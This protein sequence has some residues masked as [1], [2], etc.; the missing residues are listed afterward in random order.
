MSLQIKFSLLFFITVLSL[1]SQTTDRVLK[2]PEEWKFERIDFPLDYA[3]DITWKGFEELRFSPGMF[4]NSSEDYFKY[5][6]CVSIEDDKSINKEEITNFLNSYYKGLC[7]AVNAKKKYVI[8]YNKIRASV[9]SLSD[10]SYQASV[11]FF[12]SFTNGDQVVL[13]MSLEIQ[14]RSNTTIILATVIANEESDKLKILHQNNL[15]NNLPD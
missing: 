8:D 7:K 4:D 5:Y 11:I 9:K 2:Y 6:F 1:F 3:K 14:K 12:D 10:S 15:S 13:E